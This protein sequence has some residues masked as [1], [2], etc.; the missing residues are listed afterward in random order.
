MSFEQLVRPFAARPVTT[1]SR[2]IPTVKPAVSETAILSWGVAGEIPQGVKQEAGA[3][4]TGSF[5]VKQCNDDWKQKGQPETTL[6]DV[7]TLTAAGAP[8]GIIARVERI[9]KIRFEKREQQQSNPS[10]NAFVASAV[11]E[12]VAGLK[13]A[14][15]GPN[16]CDSS[17]SYKW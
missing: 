4:L 1:T 9:D 2:V 11:A 14:I 16:K 5:T 12:S 6:H 3:D 13:A 17:F 15:S 8:T 10:S 7:P